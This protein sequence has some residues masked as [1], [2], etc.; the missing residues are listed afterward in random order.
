M[1]TLH[2]ASDKLSDNLDRLTDRSRD[3]SYYTAYAPGSKNHPVR[4][5]RRTTGNIN[6]RPAAIFASSEFTLHLYRRK[7]RRGYDKKVL[8]TLNETMQLEPP[9][10]REQIE[11][12]HRLG[13]VTPDQQRPRTIIVRF[14]SERSRDSLQG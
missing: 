10:S 4:K 1:R 11:R 2:A 7:R 6:R 14:S 3:Y 5:N 13:R 9:I 12:C 8:Q